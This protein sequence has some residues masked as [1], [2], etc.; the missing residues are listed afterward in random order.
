MDVVT[1][2]N[3]SLAGISWVTAA[4]LSAFP[5]LL[6]LG[7]MGSRMAHGL[8]FPFIAP[9]VLALTLLGAWWLTQQQGLTGH[10]RYW[11]IAVTLA[12]LGLSLSIAAFYYDLS[13]DGEWYHQTGIIH[14]AH[15]WNPV[16][17]PMRS[18]AKHRELWVRHYA[19]GTWYAAATIYATTNYIELGKCVNSLALAAA[20]SAIT[21]A[22]LDA[23]LRRGHAIGIA[24][25]VAFNPVVMSEIVTF[26]VDGVLISFLTVAIAAIF[27]GLFN[28]WFAARAR[29]RP[30]VVVAGVAGS[31][32]CI[33]S[34][35]TGLIYL[36]FV[37]TATLIWCLVKQRESLSRFCGTAAATLV[38]G[39]LVWGYN[40]YVTNTLYRHQPFYPMLGSAEYP[41]LS[42]QGKDGN[43]QLETP[44]NMVGRPRWVRFGYAIFGRPGNPPYRIGRN[45]VLM[46]PF[47]ARPGDLYAYNYHE[48]RISGFGPFFSG[49][50][51]LSGALGIW[52]LTPARTPYRFAL[53]L[54]P[55]TIVAS[56]MLSPHLWWPR[57]GPQLWLLPVVPLLFAFRE[58]SS[59]LRVRLTSALVALLLV[60]A[61]VVAAVRMRWETASTLTLRRQLRELRESG[62]DYDFNTGYFDESIRLRL[63]DAGVRFHDLGLSRLP[64]SQ[65]LTSVVEGYPLS[66]RFRATD[67]K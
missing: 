26:L 41:S 38:L 3:E 27:T 32:V 18:F 2:K 4:A 23:G 13:W 31:I 12:V 36:C 47:T 58:E 52:L 57:Y 8:G 7:A 6:Q 44:K 29:P 61:A 49:C 55:A 43:E 66:I 9:I 1:Q 15:D 17:D 54:I 30:A 60:N 45:A 59:R 48:T 10:A 5:C 35:F 53:L 63:T 37:F 25:V 19:K 64:H 21:A 65:I 24:A 20:F 39:V 14:I 42:Q 51:L 62:I 67:Q 56:L 16:T 40:P 28:G 33:S 11:P 34:K 22:S 46:W 50:F